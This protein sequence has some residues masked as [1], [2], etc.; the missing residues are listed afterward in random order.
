L[1]VILIPSRGTGRNGEQ[2]V[3]TP[4]SPVPTAKRE[5]GTQND[6]NAMIY[7]IYR[8]KEL[9]FIYVCFTFREFL[10]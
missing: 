2:W 3:A 5:D 6:K 8:A 10:Q 1:P 7:S 4:C 9:F